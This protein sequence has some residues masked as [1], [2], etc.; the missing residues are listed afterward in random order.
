MSNY[1]NHKVKR[2]SPNEPDHKT[3][4]HVRQLYYQLYQKASKY[5]VF[6]D[7]VRK[8]AQE[9]YTLINYGE[10]KKKMLSLNNKS[11]LKMRD[12]VYK[13]SVTIRARGKNI[14][15]KTP[16]CRALRK[17]N[18]LEGSLEDVQ[19]P[20]RVE[21]V[22]RP[23]SMESWGKV[24]SLAQNPRLRAA[25]PLHRRVACL[26]QAIQQKW[27]GQNV[28]LYEKYVIQPIQQHGKQK[29][30]NEI[31]DKVNHFIEIPLILLNFI[32]F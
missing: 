15:I 19:L 7:D 10:M 11:F 16:S 25:L 28:R 27:R 18:Q 8:N 2:K 6:S 5:L 26:L 4:D 21:V 17:L 32:N 12:L 3:K 1:I 23:T 31:I 20:S 9:L 29:L 22:L 14:K 13:G 30:T 24:Q